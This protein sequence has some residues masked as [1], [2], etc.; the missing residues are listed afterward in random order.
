MKLVIFDCDGTIVDSQNG[1]MRAMTHAFEAAGLMPPPRRAVLD[2]VGLSLNEA[3]AKLAPTARYD[4]R[5]LLIAH[6]RDAFTVLRNQPGS[7]D[8]L[9]EGAREVIEALAARDDLVLGIATG[10]SVRGV[11]RLF[12]QE[13]FAPH[14][15]TVQTADHHPSK[16]HPAMIELAMKDVGAAPGD[17]VMIGDTTYDIEM[18]VN[19]GV[20]ALGVSWG[21]HPTDWLLEAGA[22]VVAQCYGD[23]IGHV[24]GLL[25]KGKGR[26]GGGKS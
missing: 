1:I 11:E 25:A 9:Y 14:F 3:F 23:V 16:P 22:E 26:A 6:Y 20:R 2:I 7:D 17:T 10:K 13:G 8:P 4:Q 5:A 21:Y 18:A 19:A 24:D 15:A 12:K